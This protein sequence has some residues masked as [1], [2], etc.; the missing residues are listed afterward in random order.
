VKFLALK[1]RMQQAGLDASRIQ[2]EPK[3]LDRF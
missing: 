3:L 1:N 2:Y